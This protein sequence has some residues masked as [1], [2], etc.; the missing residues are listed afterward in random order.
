MKRYIYLLPLFFALGCENK[1]P[2]EQNI[3][4]ESIQKND[5]KTSIKPVQNDVYCNARFGYC[6]DYPGKTLFPQ[7]ESENGDGRVFVASDSNELM[8]VYGYLM[9]NPEEERANVDQL[10]DLFN[11]DLKDADEDN[12]ND[13]LKVTYKKLGKNFFII[14]GF[15][16]GKIYYQ[17]TIVNK[18]AFA[19][20]IMQYDVKDSSRYNEISST[21]SKSFR[22]ANE[23]SVTPMFKDTAL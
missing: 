9:W 13:R 22:F 14:S 15:K 17:K 20:V 18:D 12:S 4:K 2:A 1:Q 16:K 6:I 11:R 8:R 23:P 3:T 21:V 7:T 10:K 19:N 5:N